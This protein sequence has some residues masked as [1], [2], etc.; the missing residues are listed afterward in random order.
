MKE[1]AA[2]I[3]THNPEVAARVDRRVTLRGGRVVELHAE[4][5]GGRETEANHA[6]RFV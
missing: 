4:A 5:P 6:G 1:E 3:A 2:L